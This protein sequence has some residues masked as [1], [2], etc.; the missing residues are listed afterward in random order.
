MV[1]RKLICP[2]HSFEGS[3]K[4][5]GGLEQRLLIKYFIKKLPQQEIN[6]L[7]EKGHTLKEILAFDYIAGYN[8]ENVFNA[9]IENKNFIDYITGEIIRLKIEN[10]D[11]KDYI[12][13]TPL[14]QMA[15][16][17]YKNLIMEDK[18][19]EMIASAN[20][21]EDYKALVVFDVIFRE[22]SSKRKNMLDRNMTIEEKCDRAAVLYMFQIGAE[23]IKVE[24][25]NIDN[26]IAELSK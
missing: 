9:A 22:L 25:K 6:L 12:F 13:Q 20:S 21:D 15:V 5:E 1:T 11:K 8:N 19:Q 17:A 3:C 10:K 18:S 2:K 7:L 14:R 26:Y 23:R 16:L 4:A 24:V